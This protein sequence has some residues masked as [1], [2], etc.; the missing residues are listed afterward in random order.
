VARIVIGTRGSALALWQARH[1][2]ALLAQRHPGLEIEEKIIHSDGDLDRV[3]SIASLGETGVFV[4]RLEQ[5]LLAHEIDLAV[6]SLK[7]LPSDQPTG[8]LVAAVPERH[9]ARDALVSVEGWTLEDLPEATVVCTGSFRRRCQ[10]LHTRPDLRVEPIRGNVDTRVR[11]MREGHCGAIVLAVAGLERLGID[12]VAVR[13]IE[14]EVCLPAVGQGALAIE[15]RV[16]DRATREIAEVLNHDASLK[17]VTAERAFL[18]R[19]GG[20]CQAPA[21][22]YARVLEEQFV[23]DAVVGDPQGSAL[24]LDR[25]A[26]V[27]EEAHVIGARLAE[28]LIV[29]GAKRMIDAARVEAASNDG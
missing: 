12:D 8:L 6:H 11:K 19:L 7:D 17:A 5:A 29:A 9:D 1:V 26:G 27:V 23:V 25:E 4:R 13:P 14:P 20:G 2:A 28:R 21:S 10:L 18:R 3:S 24:L 16:D 15:A 22:A